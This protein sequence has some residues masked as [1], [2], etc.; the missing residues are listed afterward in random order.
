MLN[1]NFEGSCELLSKQWDVM[2]V[3]V[4]SVQTAICPLYISISYNVPILTEAFM[5]KGEPGQTDGHTRTI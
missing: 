4:I 3:S 2:C 5:Y 1:K